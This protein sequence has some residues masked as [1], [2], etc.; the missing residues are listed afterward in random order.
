MWGAMPN[1]HRTSQESVHAGF[2]ATCRNSRIAGARQGGCAS[3]PRTRTRLNSLPRPAIRTVALLVVASALLVLTSCGNGGG[4]PAFTGPNGILV[5]YN[6]VPPSPL[7]VG[8]T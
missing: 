7:Q 1:N 3:E 5:T 2:L 4:V 8:A 6:Q